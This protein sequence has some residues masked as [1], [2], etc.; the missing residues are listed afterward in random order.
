VVYRIAPPK[1]I[2]KLRAH[3]LD[4]GRASGS[5]FKVPPLG[6]L[7][8]CCNAET[9]GRTEAF[10]PSTDKIQADRVEVPVCGECSKHAL[11]SNLRVLMT[12]S[13]GAVGLSLMGLGIN[14]LIERPDD[15]FLFWVIGTGAALF[16]LVTALGIRSWRARKALEGDGHHPGFHITVRPGRVSLRTTNADFAQRLID[17]GRASR[18]R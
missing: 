10:D 16:I 9:Y 4:L 7:C 6:Q 13:G 3:V 5:T 2:E 18:I 12:L 15:S 8:V 1:Q 14:Y 11:E 17:G